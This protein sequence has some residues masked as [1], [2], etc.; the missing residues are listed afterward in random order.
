M[1]ELVLNVV[2]YRP[3]LRMVR[4]KKFVLKHIKKTIIQSKKIE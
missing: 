3:K 2:K 1:P 4:R